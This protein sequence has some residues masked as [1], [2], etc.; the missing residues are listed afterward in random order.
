[1]YLA[2]PHWEIDKEG[3]VI[4]DKKKRNFTSLPSPGKWRQRKYVKHN[5]DNSQE[6][7][8]DRVQH[9]CTPAIGKGKQTLE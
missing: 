7:K 1:M 8:Q 5:T 4:C 9:S 3:S 2:A 6:V